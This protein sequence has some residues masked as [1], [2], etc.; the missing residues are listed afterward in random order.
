MA[1]GKQ[2]LK[3]CGIGCGAAIVLAIVAAV[4]GSL[5]MMRPFDRAVD[6]QMELNERFGARDAYV[7]PLEGLTPQQIDRFL[8][9]RESLLPHCSK[10]AEMAEPFQAMQEL[11]KQEDKP[12]AGTLLRTM[13]DLTGSVMGLAGN[14]GQFTQDRNEALLAQGMGLGEYVWIYTLVYYCWLGHAPQDELEE[15]ESVELDA[16]EARAVRS[17]LGNL[18]RAL[19]AA[20]RQP[21][22][23]IWQGE[24]D[25]LERTDAA[26][27]F[28]AGGLPAPLAELLE[29]RRA[30][31][32][33]TFCGALSTYEFG[34]VQK[35][36][37]S[38]HSR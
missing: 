18:A 30:Q 26:I 29:S 19:T 21:E 7:P 36:G 28:A 15:D 17:L 35:K 24:A 5:F 1:T 6:A 4:G 22:A 14:I 31:L 33:P 2:W 38:V 34:E 8:R 27:P 20:G 23:D 11:D 9:V 25:R 13:G 10:F 16:G 12:S 3:G 32:E 37:L